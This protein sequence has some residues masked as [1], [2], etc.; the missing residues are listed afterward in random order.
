MASAARPPGAPSPRR[1]IKS[2]AGARSVG[3]LKSR[4]L[5]EPREHV[6]GPT[7]ICVQTARGPASA[8]GPPR[9]AASGDKAHFTPAWAFLLPC[10]AQRRSRC[11][12]PAL[13]AP[14]RKAAR[15]G[16]G[17]SQLQV[18]VENVGLSCTQGWRRRWRIT[19]ENTAVR[20]AAVAAFPI[21]AD[22][23]GASSMNA[24]ESDS[25]AF[26][27]EK[28]GHGFQ[29]GNPGRPVF[30]RLRRTA[31]PAAPTGQ[32]QLVLRVTRAITARQGG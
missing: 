22:H 25:F 29:Q 15:T 12:P 18:K 16:L 1:K 23:G 19:R 21:C 28:N 3:S 17:H 9:P 11:S 27:G 32:K 31:C 8:G 6:R 2:G 5:D 20:P 24:E 7:H 14:P 4:P 13:H 10:R 26:D 30:A